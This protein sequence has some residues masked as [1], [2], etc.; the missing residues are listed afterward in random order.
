MNRVAYWPLK[1]GAG[2]SVDDEGPSN[3]TGTVNGAQWVTSCP[4]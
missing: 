4:Q 3:Y 1:E 2:A